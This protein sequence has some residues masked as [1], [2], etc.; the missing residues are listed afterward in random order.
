MVGITYSD[1]GSL[2]ASTRFGVWSLPRLD[3]CEILI[4]V[5]SLPCTTRF[6]CLCSDSKMS[7]VTD[8]GKCLAAESVGAD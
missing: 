1:L 6:A 5:V 7:N 8:T 3:W 2:F 4:R